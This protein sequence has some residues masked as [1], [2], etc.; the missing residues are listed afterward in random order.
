MQLRPGS[1]GQTPC[2]AGVV[3]YFRVVENDVKHAGDDD[4]KSNAGADAG[5]IKIC[6]VDYRSYLFARK[7]GTERFCLTSLKEG[8]RFLAIRQIGAVGSGGD[9]LHD[10]A[11]SFDEQG[12]IAC[13]G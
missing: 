4:G 2:S 3:R 13:G 9:L 10:G 11:F 5:S 6:R 1:D 12:R 7:E 8:D